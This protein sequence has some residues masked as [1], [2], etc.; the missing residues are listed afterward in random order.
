MWIDVGFLIFLAYGFYFGYSRGIIKT[1]YSIISILVAILLSFKLSPFLIDFL[2]ASLK[3]GPTFS[4]ILG[5][6]L[7]FIVIVFVVRLI[8][9]LFEK[10]L[11]TVKLNFINKIAGGAMMSLLFV[12]CYS[13]ILW[14]LNETSII[15]EQQASQSITYER[16]E[17]IP[18]QTRDAFKQLK[19]AFEGFWE[20]S[21]EAIRESKEQETDNEIIQK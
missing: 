17:P 10:V 13:W 15:T 5:F 14:F 8:G 6:V 1:I 20:K 4:F 16:L 7:T 2:E 3:L 18:N 11:K 21:T 12:L 9:K 19:P